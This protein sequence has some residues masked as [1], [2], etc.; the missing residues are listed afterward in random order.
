MA[1]REA[2]DGG[3]ERVGESLDDREV[4]G[5]ADA[6]T[7]GDDDRR[8][9]Q[10]GALALLLDDPVDDARGLGGLGELDRD[11]DPL[12]RAAAAARPATEL[13]RTVMIGVPV[14][15]LDLTMVE[16]PKTCCSARTAPPSPVTSVASVMTP[17]PVLIASRAGDLLAVGRRREQHRG[18]RAVGDELGEHLG[19]RGDQV[20]DQVGRRRRRTPSRAV[21]RQRLLRGVEAG[22]DQD[23]GGLAQARGQRQQLEGDLLD[24]AVD[25]LDEN[26]DL[27]HVV[28]PPALRRTSWT[29]GTR[30]AC[31]PRRP[32]P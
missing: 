15:T 29:R 31:P 8:L 9:G 25:V 12:G 17:E 27:C 22:A 14:L 18:G 23:G 3:T 7:A 21:L 20:V 19:D 10:L 1:A 4:L 30:G 13:G 11:V 26:Q 6:A 5:R 16:P 28:S 2:P 32:R 24:L